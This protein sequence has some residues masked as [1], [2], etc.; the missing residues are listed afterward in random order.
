MGMPLLLYP[1]I[2]ASAPDGCARLAVA[3]SIHASVPHHTMRR[4]SVKATSSATIAREFFSPYTASGC[5]ARGSIDNRNHGRAGGDEE[6]GCMGYRGRTQ[7]TYIVSGW[8][9]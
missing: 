4:G 8:T 6:G 9:G 2:T 5:G 7:S 1:N 3:A